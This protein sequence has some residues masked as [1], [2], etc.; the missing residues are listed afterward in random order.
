MGRVRQRGGKRVSAF[1]IEGNLDADAISS[2]TFE[3]EWPPKS[4]R[5]QS[6]PEVDRAEWFDLARRRFSPASNCF[7]IGSMKLG[8]PAKLGAAKLKYSIHRRRPQGSSSSR[9]TCGNWRGS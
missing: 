3:M 8:P 1:A 5:R 6:F 2:D 4:G 9:R 7:S